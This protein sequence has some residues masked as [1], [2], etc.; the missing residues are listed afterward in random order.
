MIMDRGQKR[1]QLKRRLL[2]LIE[3]NGEGG[4]LPPE[5]ELSERFD[6][7]RETLRRCLRELELDGLL[8]RR[9]GAGTFVSGQP[10]VKQPQLLS[11]S[12]EMRE[13][14]LVPTSELLG[15][16]TIAAGAKLAHKL[17]VIPGT[18]VVEMR[19]LRLASDEPMALE[20]VYLIQ[21]KVPG[22]DAASL[23]TS[24]LYELLSQRF[25][26]PLRAASQ[27]IQA[28][29]LNEEE[30]DLL[31]VAPFSPSL[32]IERLSHAGSG[33]VVEYA[34]SLY[35]ADRYRF[36][37]N[38]MRPISGPLLAELGDLDDEDEDQ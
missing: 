24:S 38:V 31:G 18:A 1:E 29:V 26:L 11:F 30:A 37:I 36:E 12:E 16:R 3:Q 33:E 7:A 9:Q 14:G 32:L 20:T 35:R 27:Q 5:R 23:A 8:Q 4:R 19:R 22:F 6:V 2:E 13:R 28:T 21:A 10:V 34:K 25:G 17:K 15:C